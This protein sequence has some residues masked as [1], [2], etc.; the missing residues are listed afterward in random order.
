MVSTYGLDNNTVIRSV[1]EL[2]SVVV[3]LASRDVPVVCGDLDRD[4]CGE[5]FVWD[6]LRIGSDW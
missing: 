2:S 6:S 5:V 4:H 3:G 1:A